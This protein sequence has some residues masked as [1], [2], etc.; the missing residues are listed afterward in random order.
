MSNEVANDHQTENVPPCIECPGCGETY[1]AAFQ[2]FAHHEQGGFWILTCRNLACLLV[3][4]TF[5][6][7][8]YVWRAP[9]MLAHLRAAATEAANVS[10]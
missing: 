1:H 5:S 10:H 9:Q 6:I 4:Q 7:P 3:G 2:R 8:T